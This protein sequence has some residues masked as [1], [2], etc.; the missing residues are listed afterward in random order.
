MNW[1]K[2]TALPVIFRLTS[3][4]SILAKTLGPRSNLFSPIVSSQKVWY[5]RADPGRSQKG[6][7]FY[8]P[9]RETLPVPVCTSTPPVYLPEP[10]TPQFQTPVFSEISGSFHLA[11]ELHTYFIRAQYPGR[12]ERCRFPVSSSQPLRMCSMLELSL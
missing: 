6:P 12:I 9:P 5:E 1:L 10:T 11:V 4:F 2:P 8:F 7:E 3:Q